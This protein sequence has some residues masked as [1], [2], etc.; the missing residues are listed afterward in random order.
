MNIITRAINMAIKPKEEWPV[1]AGE[2]ATTRS[3]MTGF[4]MPLA[5]I[6]AICGFIQMAY[7][8]S[9]LSSIIDLRVSFGLALSTSIV[10][11][12]LTLVGVLL[13]A[14]IVSKLA[15]S[16]Q[17]SDDFVKALKLVAY[18]QGPLWLAGVLQLVP[19]LGILTIF[20]GL[21]TIYLIYLGFTPVLGTPQ[22][23][24]IPYMIVIVV[25]YFVIMFIFGMI[26]TAMVGMSLFA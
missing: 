7:I 22:D 8:G 13:A 1:I 16:F 24:I 6:G 10:G 26:T 20:V 15:P 21:Y 19:F 9:A 11:Y 4:V 18:V 12:V 14:F 3:I 25:V 2:S 23:K 5:A 17:S